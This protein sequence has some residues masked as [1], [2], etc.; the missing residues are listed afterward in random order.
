[1]I[2]S[3][4][5]TIKEINPDIMFGISPAG[6]ISYAESIG[7]D[8]KTWI[9]KKGYTDYLIPQLYWS[10]YY[11]QSG[12]KKIKYYTKTL[13]EWTSLNKEKKPLYI[14]L[15]LYKAGASLPEDPGWK[16]HKNNLSKQLDT[17]RENNCGG[18]VIFSYESMFTKAGRKEFSNLSKKLN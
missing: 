3:V 18:F 6:N 9:N 15:A 2:A 16:K 13:K 10:D 12:G 5:K 4:Y 14:G 11:K 8:L 7:C 17:L 1:M